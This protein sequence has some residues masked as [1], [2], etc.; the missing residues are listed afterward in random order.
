L[1]PANVEL[2]IESTPPGAEV[3]LAGRGIG[4]TPFHGS[5]A[6]SA[7]NVTLVLRLPG[8]ADRS[9]VVHPDRAISERIKLVA[10]PPRVNHDK[11][12]NPF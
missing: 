7:G 6:R 9:V 1:Q 11:S 12:V 5:L 3:V 2:A 10:A 8:Y 4:K